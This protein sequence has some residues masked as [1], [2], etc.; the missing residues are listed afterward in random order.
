MASDVI[1]LMIGISSPGAQINRQTLCPLIFGTMMS[2]RIKS[3]GV[4]SAVSN[5]YDRVMSP[6][7]VPG[8]VASAGPLTPSPGKATKSPSLRIGTVVAPDVSRA[9]TTASRREKGWL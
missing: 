5:R 3:G 9:A 2:S 4:P 8:I 7:V 6:G 1:Y